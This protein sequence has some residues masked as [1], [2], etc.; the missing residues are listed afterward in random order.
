MAKTMIQSAP[1][2]EIQSTLHEAMQGLCYWVAHRHSYYYKHPLPEGAIVAELANL[3]EGRLPT[4]QHLFCEIPYKNIFDHK[5]KV[6]YFKESRFSDARMDLL[7]ASEKVSVESVRKHDFGHGSNTVI[8]VKRGDTL[9]AP[10][11]Q[12]LLKL[13]AVKRL[14]PNISTFLLLVSEN[15]LPSQLKFFANTGRGN[16]VDAVATR[17]KSYVDAIEGDVA[18]RRVCKAMAS[19]KAKQV[20]TA[21]LVEVL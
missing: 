4:G 3:I 5:S 18:I 15:K 11:F 2:K 10:F 1:H 7:I 9:K 21:V 12:D 13:A 19:S 8:E 16:A 6:D 20:H 17:Q 14:S